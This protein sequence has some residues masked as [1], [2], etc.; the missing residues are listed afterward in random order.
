MVSAA[1]QVIERL[2]VR[3]TSET[4]LVVVRKGIRNLLAYLL[5]CLCL[6]PGRRRAHTLDD[7]PPSSSVGRQVWNVLPE[8]VELLDILPDEVQPSGPR[9]SSRSSP[10]GSDGIKRQYPGC[11]VWV[12]KT[13][14]VS[15]PSDTSF[16]QRSDDARLTGS[17]SDSFVCDVFPPAHSFDDT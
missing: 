17:R 14:Y 15:K 12:R 7:V 2:K 13:L 1:S 4:S 16:S 10:A 11:R 6:M 5:A 9:G 8:D 3:V